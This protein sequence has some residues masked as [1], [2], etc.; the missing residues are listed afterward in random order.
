M[1]RSPAHAARFRPQTGEIHF[2]DELH[3]ETHVAPPGASAT[4]GCADQRP[5][6]ERALSRGPRRRSPA[7]L[8]PD[9]LRFSNSLTSDW[10]RQGPGPAPPSAAR[11]RGPGTAQGSGPLARRWRCRRPGSRP[12]A[13][14]ARCPCCSLSDHMAWVR[15]CRGQQDQVGVPPG[16]GHRLRPCVGCR[17][18]SDFCSKKYV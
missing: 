8:C 10:H 12:A 14:T 11:E 3:G 13:C 6:A 1:C 4:L 17:A 5:A 7:R 9:W 16:L 15:S 18:H 2:G